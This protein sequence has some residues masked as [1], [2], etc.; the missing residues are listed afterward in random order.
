MKKK[1]TIEEAKEAYKNALNEYEEI[2]SKIKEISSTLNIL[3]SKYESATESFNDS[4]SPNFCNYD[5]LLD[6][7]DT[8]EPSYNREYEQLQ[9]TKKMLRI[10]LVKLGRA[11]RLYERMCKKAGVEKVDLKSNQP[12]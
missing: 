6:I 12:E 3:S 10:A 4:K 7:I 11:K 8:I 2:S 9:I 1:I 5:I